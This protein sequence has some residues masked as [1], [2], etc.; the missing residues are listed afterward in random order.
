MKKESLKNYSNLS[1]D[2]TNIASHIFGEHEKFAELEYFCL[3]TEPDSENFV[4][5][6]IKEGLFSK[7]TE[8]LRYLAT[9]PALVCR[10][11]RL[12]FVKK[13]K[14]CSKP[15]AFSIMINKVRPSITE[16]TVK[17]LTCRAV[18]SKKPNVYS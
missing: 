10:T 14:R 8:I 12:S 6:M 4:C 11:K 18:S 7:I 2:I 5:E 16:N 17:H 3:K 1:S 15:K 13:R 9:I